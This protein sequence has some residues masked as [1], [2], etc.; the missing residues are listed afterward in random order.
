MHRW[1]AQQKRVSPSRQLDSNTQVTL[2][3]LPY[4]LKQLQQMQT[5][6]VAI[7]A[8]KNEIQ[9]C[10]AILHKLPM[11]I[12]TQYLKDKRRSWSRRLRQRQSVLWLEAEGG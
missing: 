2:P 12:Y 8:S 5:A 10:T 6:A 7:V 3:E 11:A 1:L 9:Q 4:T